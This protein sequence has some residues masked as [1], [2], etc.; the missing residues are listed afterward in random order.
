[1]PGPAEAND[2][3]PGLFLGELD[4]IGDR[5]HRQV[6]IDHQHERHARDQRDRRD[7]LARIVRQALAHVDVDRERGARRHHDGVAVGRAVRDR[8]RRRHAAAAR[9][10]DRPRTACRAA[11]R[12]S[13]P[14][15][16]A[17]SP[18][19]PPGANGTTKV[20][21]LLGYSFA[22]SCA[23]ANWGAASASS[24]PSKAADPIAFIRVPSRSC[25]L[26]NATMRK[27]QRNP[28]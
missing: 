19:E 13:A 5:L 15:T 7:V 9:R 4:E 1:M 24:K 3:W 28:Y 20:T 12:A 2:S 23:C 6:G 8:G 25:L 18:V 26:R 10:D 21:G 27:P 16:R 22:V 11:A 14:M 17:I